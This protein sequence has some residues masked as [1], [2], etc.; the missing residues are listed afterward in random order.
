MFYIYNSY[1]YISFHIIFS[2]MYYLDN[3]LLKK[4]SQLKDLCLVILDYFGAH[5]DSF[6]LFIESC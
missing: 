6:T 2:Q 1:I 4:A 3:H 5:F